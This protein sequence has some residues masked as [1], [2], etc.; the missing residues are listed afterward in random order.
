[1]TPALNYLTVQ[2]ILF[3]HFRIVGQPIPF[4]YDKLEEAT[5][6]QYG[7]GGSSDLTGQ[8]ANFATGFRKLQPFVTA[9]RAVGFV[10]LLAFLACNGKATGLTD[11][12]ALDWFETASVA[13]S[14]DAI[15]Q[16][17]TDADSHDRPT[18]QQAILA[19]IARFPRSIEELVAVERPVSAT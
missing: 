15:D 14:K 1:M 3:A 2:D 13:S 7:Y 10:A 5:F 11:D 18:A 8:A 16:A 19:V 12:D 4:Q 9:N 17:V 6:C